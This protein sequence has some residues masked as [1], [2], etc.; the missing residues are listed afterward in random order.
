MIFLRKC[1]QFLS[2]DSVLPLIAGLASG[3]YPMAFYY[4]KN[5]NFV[6]SW[7]H[8]Y[9]FLATFLILPITINYLAYFIFKNKHLS[10]YKTA[11][12]PL[13]NALAF[14]IL[15]I[16]AIDSRIG[17][18]KLVLAVFLAFVVAITCHYIK[19]L[20]PKILTIQFILLLVVSYPL[21]KTIKYFIGRTD[22][23]IEQ[24]DH[25]MDVKLKTK[26]NIYVIQP[27]GYVN[28]K[29]LSKGYYQFDN[30]H[31]ENW[32]NTQDFVLY[33]DMRSNYPSTMSSNS[34]MF[35]MKHHYYN[36]VD[37]RG[38]I[39]NLNPLVDI[40]KNNNYKTHFLA[41]IPYLLA[42]RPKVNFDYVN[43]KMR[44]I[45]YLG[46]GFGVNKS[47]LEDVVP[48]LKN[49]TGSNFYFFEK[50]QPGHISTYKKSG[51]SVNQEKEEYL[52]ELQKA[53]E[54]LKELITL[55]LDNDTNALIVII[56]DHG[57]YV[58]WEY[59]LQSSTKTQDRDLLYSSFSTMLAIRWND[60]KEAENMDMLKTSV[61]LFRVV[62]AHLSQDASLL[63][64]LQENGSYLRISE[65][66]PVG[67][68]KVLD[69]SGEVVFEK[70]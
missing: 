17:N 8:L 49:Q 28:H 66:A 35:A 36:Q 37:E 6:N 39:M 51:G 38:T 52:D 41:E 10:R 44:E 57:G 4:S 70:K 50:L 18:K 56:A 20:F 26:P 31:F 69:E 1:I 16:I 53:N 27:D 58:G 21:A 9:F 12:L 2:K 34:S 55:I 11:V 13:L 62:L 65:G 22:H 61:N 15:I 48:L 67:L 43:F 30:S 54:W 42:N 24:P 14:F 59:S 47:I 60:K 19:K 23:W 32:L 5:F 3:L 64:N 45:P 68:Y 40:L 7:S 33:P 29:E 25:I 46:R 63:Q